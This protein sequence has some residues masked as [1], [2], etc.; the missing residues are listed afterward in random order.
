MSW[1]TIWSHA[2]RGIAHHS[3]GE[4]QVFLTLR[5]IAPVGTIRLV[6]ANDYGDQVEKI[7]N[8]F[9]QTNDRRQQIGDL[10]IAPGEIVRTAPISIDPEAQKWQITFQNDLMESGFAVNDADVFASISVSNFCSGLL[11]IEAEVAGDC[12]IALGDSLTEGATWTAPLQRMFREQNIYLVN[13]GINGSCLLRSSSDIMTKDSKDFFYGY[14]AFHRLK[15]CF[16]SHKGIKKVI[17]FIGINDLIHGDLSVKKFQK[18]IEKII[19]VCEYEKVAYQLCTLTPCMNYPEM[20]EQK[21]KVRKEINRWLLNTY[22]NVWDISSIVE[23]S[24]GYLNP[25]FDS[26]DHLHFNAIA[27]LAIAR[28]ISSEFVKGE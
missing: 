2:Q 8:L 22:T 18:E 16:A 25:M 15:K 17:L 21:E 7:R 19:Q 4:K 13:Q 10:S 3:N 28:Q 11:A 14:S 24:S 12:V 23:K 9:I 5:Q 27:G 1:T 6:F 26:G 20:D